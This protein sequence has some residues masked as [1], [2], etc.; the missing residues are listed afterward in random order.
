MVA[1]HLYALKGLWLKETLKGFKK[2]AEKRTHT[3]HG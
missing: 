1:S 2:E 3:I